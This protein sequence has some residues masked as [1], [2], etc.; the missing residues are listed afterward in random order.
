MVEGSLFWRL[1]TCLWVEEGCGSLDPPNG[2]QWDRISLKV[3]KMAALEIFGSLSC[4]FMS[5]TWVR[6]NVVLIGSV[7]HLFTRFFYKLIQIFFH[8]L[9]FRFEIWLT[10]PAPQCATFAESA[11]TMDHRVTRDESKCAGFEYLV[12]FSYC[13]YRKTIFEAQ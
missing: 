3:I 1:T 9:D 7:C 5:R 10:P 8:F 6:L 2:I 4:L 13:F 11:S 12:I